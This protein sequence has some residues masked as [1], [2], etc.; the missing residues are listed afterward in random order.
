MRREHVYSII[1]V[2]LFMMLI[3]VEFVLNKS[4]APENVLVRILD[5]NDRPEIGADCVAD[6]ILEDS[7]IE[8]KPLKELESIYD[9]IDPTIFHTD[10]GEEGYYFLETDFDEY[11]G[12]YEIKIVCRSAGNRGVSYT[13]INDTNRNCE[14]RDNGRFLVC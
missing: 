4:Y 14:L 8:N 2:V 10:A 1:F 12:E 6:L 13:I 3:Q 9:L 5:T 11:G 7:M